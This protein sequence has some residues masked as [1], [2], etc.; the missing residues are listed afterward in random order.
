M[1]RH[2]QREQVLYLLFEQ[3]FRPDESMSD[4]IDASIAARE[5]E[6]TEY[7]LKTARESQMHEQEL[8]E[9]FEKHL[10]GWKKERL[11]KVILCILR[12]SLDELRYCGEEIP[13][14]AAI[15]EAVELAKTYGSD[16]DW[17]FVNGILSSVAKDLE[18][19]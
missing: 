5:M 7:I 2:E 16:D 8:D 13:A 10:T 4:I 15:N 1:T 17:S 14:A 11:P 12:L 9:L 6:P 18:L 19:S 3:C